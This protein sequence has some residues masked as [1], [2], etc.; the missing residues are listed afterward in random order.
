M[1]RIVEKLM[2]HESQKAELLVRQE[3]EWLSR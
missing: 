1:E 2:L 3:E